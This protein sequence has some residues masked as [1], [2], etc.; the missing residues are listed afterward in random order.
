MRSRIATV[1]AVILV[2]TAHA[3]A[4]DQLIA[5]LKARGKVVDDLS[6]SI[7][8]APTDQIAETLA[9]VTRQ[10][11]EDGLKQDRPTIVIK[12]TAGRCRVTIETAAW[13]LWSEAE[14][15]KIINH[16]AKIH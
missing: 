16:G 11:L 9:N 8:K 4:N 5:Q 12:A 14:A 13:N 10:T 7:S 3:A 15:G 6:A 1:I 2:S